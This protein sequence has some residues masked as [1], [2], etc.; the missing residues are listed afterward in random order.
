MEATIETLPAR[1]I[2]GLASFRLIPRIETYPVVLHYAQTAAGKLLIL[3]LFAVGLRL[4]IQDWLPL[5]LALTVIA[6]FPTHRRL[7]LTLATLVF[8]FVLPWSKFVN[9]F[10]SVTLLVFMISTAALFFWLSIE[11]PHSLFGRRPIFFLLGTF[12]LVVFLSSYLPQTSP[13][14]HTIWDFLNVF[15]MY[16]WFIAYCLLDRR[17]PER[18]DFARQVGTF[19][20]FWGSPNV[21]FVKGAAYLRRIEA[22]DG[23]Q[24][25]VTQ[26]KGL[27]LLLW[28]ILL[29]YFS[30]YFAMF[31]HGTLLIPTFS[32]AFFRSVHRTPYP[33]YTCWASLIVSFLEDLLFISIIGHRIVAC[34]R[35]AGFNALRNTYRPLS[36]RSIAEF[37]NRY[38]YYFKELLVEFFFYPAFLRFFKKRR[39]LRLVFA[40]FAAAF[41]GNIFYHFF[42]RL[43]FIVQLGF[44]HSLAGF[45]VYV[46]YCFLLASGISVSQLR[47]GR[48]KPTGFLRARVLPAVSVVFFYILINIFAYLGRD[49]PIREHFRFFAHLFPFF[50]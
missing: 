22:R 1:R 47:A 2:P 9:P 37:W 5:S 50:S 12:A 33:W 43:D 26:L 27:K 17:A 30:K 10:Y 36:S 3:V 15:G 19:R 16:L 23:Q 8:A 4:A 28:S 46:F 38:Y 39:K 42:Q 11:L 49:Y 48:A 41:F 20:P 35:M 29:M 24:L 6:F 14:Y 34:V 13:A 45:H 31:V 18:D 21:P 7:L 25:A 44:W 40:T 32:E